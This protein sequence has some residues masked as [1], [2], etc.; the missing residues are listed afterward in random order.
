MNMNVPAAVL[1]ARQHPA[2]RVN[3]KGIEFDISP[4]LHVS[5]EKD[6][7]AIWSRWTAD[8]R[9]C[10]NPSLL[11]DIRSYYDFLATSGGQIDCFGEEHPIE[12]VI[13]ASGMPGV[14]NL[15]G[16]LDLFRQL[17]DTRD[18]QGLLR[19]G[20]AC[21]DVLYR[22]YVSHDLPVTTVSLV[23]GECLGGGFEAAL[24]SDLIVAERGA[25]FGFPEILFNLFPGMGA[26]SFLERKIGQKAAEE[27]LTSGKIYTA[28]EM[29]ALGV[30]D[31]IAEDGEGE[32]AVAALIKRR[33]RSRNG[34]A[35]LAAVRR[36]VHRIDF[37]ELLDI[38]QIWVEAALR[39]NPRDLKL[40]QR[41]VSRQNDLGESHQAHKKAEA[42]NGK[43]ST[44]DQSK[45]VAASKVEAAIGDG[46][47]INAGG[48]AGLRAENNVDA[49]A[50]A[51]ASATQ[52]KTGTGVAADV[53]LN[54]SEATTQASVPAT[55]TVD[56]GAG[57]VVLKAGNATEVAIDLKMKDADGSRMVTTRAEGG[58]PAKEGTGGN[59]ALA[60]T[61]VDNA[62]GAQDGSGA[63][64]NVNGNAEATAD[65]YGSSAT[66]AKGDPT[67]TSTAAG[68][69][70]APGFA[71]DGR[72]RRRHWTLM[73]TAG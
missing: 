33:Q 52:D 25:R 24:S 42:D 21:I 57:D 66:V 71:D 26:Y 55:V 18:G 46:L 1:E 16:D 10:F 38:V 32:A 30:V 43:V 17:I 63:A 44:D 62:T 12:Y 8:P 47:T 34:M 48:E 3:A 2:S 35:A 40:M 36:R 13:L 27:V 19:Y 23:Q 20:R 4:Q 28:E 58:G 69:V 51:H 65:G 5:F 60:I 64:L 29:H 11:A 9:P 54:Y 68:A 37:S 45:S 56:V 59:G 7:R 49:S 39:L 15:G 53:V 70:L 50:I 72:R 22:N 14:F 67:G 31:V 6:T 41:L 73:P 61:V